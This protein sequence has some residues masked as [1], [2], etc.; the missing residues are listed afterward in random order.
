MFLAPLWE[1]LELKRDPSTL[2]LERWFLSALASFCNNGVS[3]SFET[4]FVQ[5][6]VRRIKL[7]EFV[8][9]CSNQ[10]SLLQQQTAYKGGGGQSQFSAVISQLGNT[11]L[12]IRENLGK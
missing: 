7:Q 12:P 6:H 5:M 11:G 4:P 8:N 10:Q 1:G 2:C 9:K 3:C